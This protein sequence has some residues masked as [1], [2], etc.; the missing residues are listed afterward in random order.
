MVE[1]D[2]EKILKNFAKPIDKTHNVCYNIYNEK[3][4]RIT[5]KA[6]EGD[7]NEKNIHN[8]RKR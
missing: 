5:H 2:R 8:H 6:A 4:E 7:Y 1:A 3:G